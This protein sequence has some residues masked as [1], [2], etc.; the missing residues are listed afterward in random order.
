MGL[1]KSIKKAV[2]KVFKF[3]GDVTGTNYQQK[4]IKKPLQ[5]IFGLTAQKHMAA[6]QEKQLQQQS[7]VA[8]LDAASEMQNVVQFD[9]SSPDTFTGAGSR[10]KKGGADKFSSGIGLKM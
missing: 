7:E 6:A 3:T 2:G 5:D 1:F 8:K 10:R 4:K 9:D